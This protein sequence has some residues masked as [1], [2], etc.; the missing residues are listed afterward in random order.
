[1]MADVSV[2]KRYALLSTVFALQNKDLGLLT[3]GLVTLG[4][5]P[6]TTEL[7]VVIPALENA[8]RNAS[9]GGEVSERCAAKRLYS[10]HL[11]VKHANW[12]TP[13]DG[14]WLTPCDW[15]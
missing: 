6:D 12:L 13:C 9:G 1:M 4:F 11:A 7:D 2:E 5:L 3:S 15:G 10:F 8:F 14:N